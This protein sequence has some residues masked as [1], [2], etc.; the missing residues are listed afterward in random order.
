MKLVK[1]ENSKSLCRDVTSGA[2]VNTNN[3]EFRTYM[4]LKMKKLNE[5]NEKKLQ[6][7]K[8]NTLEK[9]VSEIKQLLLQLV[10]EKKD[11]NQ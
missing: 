1:V 4:E 8:I 11:A 2:I 9:E 10:K 6:E 7:D 3:E 5:L